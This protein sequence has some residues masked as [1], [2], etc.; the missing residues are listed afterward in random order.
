VS[1]CR[2]KRSDEDE[3]IS[4]CPW[5]NTPNQALEPAPSSLRCASASGRG[6]GPAFGAK[7]EEEQPKRALPNS[8]GVSEHRSDIL[9]A[10]SCIFLQ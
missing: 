4:Q 9:W 5:A 3:A 10:T 8:D 2:L 1:T 7:S 6:S